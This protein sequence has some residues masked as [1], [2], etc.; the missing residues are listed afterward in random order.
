MPTGYL[1]IPEQSALQQP[2]TATATDEEG[3]MT[4]PTSFT[5]MNDK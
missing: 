4:I 2:L 1:A 5:V 3:L